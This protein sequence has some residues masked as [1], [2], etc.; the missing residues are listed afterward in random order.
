ML[1]SSLFIYSSTSLNERLSAL[2]MPPAA[3]CWHG[4]VWSTF[5]VDHW[6]Q[7]WQI[8]LCA[9]R[10]DLSS[11]V[12]GPRS[13]EQPLLSGQLC[14]DLFLLQR[15]QSTV[16]KVEELPRGMSGSIS[17]T[18]SM[19]LE[20]PMETCIPGKCLPLLLALISQSCCVG[21]CD[22]WVDSPFLGTS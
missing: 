4:P 14:N 13:L 19:L 7:R 8:L 22:G 11:Q 15:H 18:K 2:P 3:I 16:G 21:E 10:L 5:L 17:W 6:H 12:W 9:W 20:I 1:Y